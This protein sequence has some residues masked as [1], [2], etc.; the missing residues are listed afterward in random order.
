M[1]SALYLSQKCN[2]IVYEAVGA[3][4]LSPIGNVLSNKM[5]QNEIRSGATKIRFI[6]VCAYHE[7][8]RSR[9]S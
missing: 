2:Y 8:S 7:F 1:T 9:V 4:T 5:P 3:V 6:N